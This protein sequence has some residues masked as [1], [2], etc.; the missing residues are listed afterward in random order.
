[1][2]RLDLS[3]VKEG[4]GGTAPDL[5]EPMLSTDLNFF[6]SGDFTGVDCTDIGVPLV[7]VF[8]AGVETASVSGMGGAPEARGGLAGAGLAFP[9]AAL[10]RKIAS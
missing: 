4:S 7:P 8:W 6:K 3:E 2:G 10:A 1:M 9:K 5:S